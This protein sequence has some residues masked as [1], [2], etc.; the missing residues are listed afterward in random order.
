MM[1]SGTRGGEPH[2]WNMLQLDGVYYHIDLMRQVE[3]GEKTLTLLSK[4]MLLA[5]GYAWDFVQYPSNPASDMEQEGVE[6]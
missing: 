4:E 6:S 2:Y 3:R 5:E 1:V